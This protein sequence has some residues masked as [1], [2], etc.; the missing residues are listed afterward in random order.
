M[1]V[2]R[3]AERGI[4]N[5]SYQKL[6]FGSRGTL[7]LSGARPPRP[8]STDWVRVARLTQVR[9]PVGHQLP[10]LFI[11]DLPSKYGE[12]ADGIYQLVTTQLY[13]ISYYK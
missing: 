6:P 7:S 9:K 5:T 11:A 8:G 12:L 4:I 10:L 2:G 3:I 13:K 1:H